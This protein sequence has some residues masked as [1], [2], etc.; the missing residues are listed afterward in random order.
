[1]FEIIESNCKICM[2]YNKPSLKCAV[3]FLLSKEFNDAVSVDLKYIN[4]VAVLH[5]IDNATRFSAVAVF[6]SKQQE[7]IEMSL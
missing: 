5:I 6:K 4:G 1:M 2:I 7:E 3:G